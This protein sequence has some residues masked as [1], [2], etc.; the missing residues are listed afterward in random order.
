MVSWLSISGMM[1]S[2]AV[3]VGLPVFLIVFF[4]RRRESSVFNAF[5]G[6][7]VFFVFALLLEQMLHTIM[8]YAFP[9]LLEIPAFYVAYGCLAAGIFEECGRYV[10]LRYLVNKNKAYFAS[11][12]LMFGAGHGGL[13]A[14]MIAGVACTGNLVMAFNLNANGA[15]AYTNGLS[16]AE[17][18]SM[19]RMI[20]TIT[21][22]S[23]A[24]FFFVGFER[25]SAIV[26]HMSLSVLIWMVLTGRIR[27]LWFPAAVLLHAVSNVPA[28]LYQS[29][30]LFDFYATEML[31]FAMSF[32]VAA[33][34]LV[35]YRKTLRNG[36]GGVPAAS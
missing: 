29:G 35:L 26:L 2:L 13:E 14:L 28:A 3:S 34:V 31:L 36:Q 33:V 30:V 25:V 1:V 27:K 5:I 17:L 11:D 16:G 7:C 19:N 6:A 22:A 18:E 15:A 9:S 10:G 32:A 23:P 12:A 8:S 4:N 24:Q 20:E 21:Q